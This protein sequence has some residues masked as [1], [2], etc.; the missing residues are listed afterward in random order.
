MPYFRYKQP[1]QNRLFDENTRE[2]GVAFGGILNH[3]RLGWGVYVY[4]KEMG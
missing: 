2:R 3:E 1:G 4:R